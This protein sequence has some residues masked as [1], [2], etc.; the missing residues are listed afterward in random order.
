VDGDL[1]HELP[2]PGFVSGACLAIPRETL[3]AQG[4]FDEDFFLYH[5]DVDLSLRLRLA[6]GRLGVEPTA[7]VDHEYEFAKGPAKWRQLERNRW[8]TLIRTYPASLLLLLAP[9]LVATEL[10]LIAIAASGGWLLQKLAAWGDTLSSLPRL[11]GERREIQ[12]R[13]SV[14]AA[15]FARAF[16]A[17]LDSHYLGAPA[18]SP[19]LRTL[20]RGYW[21]AVVALLGSSELVRRS[22]GSPL[23]RSERS[24]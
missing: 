17:D 22:S 20:L 4:G 24:S 6:G 2:E 19:L 15:E 14:G 23:E 10:A 1:P 5:E 9:G 11:I 18:R 13:R 12:A 7:R 3:A 21:S 16:T 8:A